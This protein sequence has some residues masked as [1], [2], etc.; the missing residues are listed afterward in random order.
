MKRWLKRFV[1][2]VILT[3]IVLAF[4]YAFQ[5][6]PV[7]A[8]FAN[9]T[10]GPL[11][12]TI[13]EEGET[14]IRQRFVVS[15]PVSGRVLR[16]SLEPGDRVLAGKTVIATFLPTDPQLLDVRSRVEAEARVRAAEAE[17]QRARANRDRIRDDLAY[18]QTQLKRAAALVEEGLI[19]RERYD[20]AVAEVR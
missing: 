19:A 12:V 20:E 9:V 2:L 4:V 14:R 15:A 16:I 3:G 1:F 8:D 5:P 18:S 10:R 17:V 11:Q 13:D 7:P 6:Q